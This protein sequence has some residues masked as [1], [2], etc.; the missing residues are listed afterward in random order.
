MI[1]INLEGI[2]RNFGT[3]RAVDDVT[4]RVGAGELFFLLG[5]S[6]CGKTTLLRCVAGFCEPDRG[7]IRCGDRDITNLSAHKRNTAMVFQSYALWPHMSVADNVGFGLENRGV[8][9]RTR[10]QKVAR[11][12]EMVRMADL[13]RR[14]P[15]QLSGG[16]QQRVAVARALVIEP[17]CLLLDEPLSNLDARLRAEMRGEIRRICK[18]SELTAIYVTHDQKEALSMADRIAVLNDGRVRQIGTPEEVYRR[19]ADRFVAG[20]VGDANFIPGRVTVVEPDL[21]TCETPFGELQSVPSGRS[22]AVGQ[23]VTLLVRPEAVAIQSAD[24][25]G[26]AA[27]LRETTYLGEMAEHRLSSPAAD[28]SIKAYELNPRELRRPGPVRCRVAAADVV[29]LP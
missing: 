15:N 10:R 3:T 13:A 11:A 23:A 14:K 21:V 25:N 6:G 2:T 8:D 12:L 7:T 26:L 29:I 24:A 16:Q 9:G 4:I 20:F 22:A 18:E 28:A 5:P 27:E 17:Q 19:P 1:P